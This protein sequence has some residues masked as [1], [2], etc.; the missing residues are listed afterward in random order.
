MNW[1]NI[2]RSFTQ[3][4]VVW[5]QPQE[6][7]DCILKGILGTTGEGSRCLKKFSKAGIFQSAL[8][9]DLHMPFPLLLLAVS[10]KLVA[11]PAREG[12]AGGWFCSNTL[13]CQCEVAS[14]MPVMTG[15][16]CCVSYNQGL[17]PGT[18]CTWGKDSPRKRRSEVW[19]RGKPRGTAVRSL[20]DPGGAW[21]KLSVGPKAG[22]FPCLCLCHVFVGFHKLSSICHLV[23]IHAYSLGS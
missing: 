3:R 11:T 16:V 4:R 18:V 20:A 15:F 13:G 22:Y 5:W 2:H 14:L 7:K 17:A 10:C 6:L 1:I 9:A 8:G 23:N 21:R 12:P 19:A